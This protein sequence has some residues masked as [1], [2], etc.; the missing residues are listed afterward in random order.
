MDHHSFVVFL[1]NVLRLPA[2]SRPEKT[3]CP[4]VAS[5]KRLEEKGKVTVTQGNSSVK[6]LPHDYIIKLTLTQLHN[7]EV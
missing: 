5:C 6:T 1:S 7:K 3:H 2:V 4:F